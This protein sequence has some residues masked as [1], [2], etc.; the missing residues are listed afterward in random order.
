MVIQT[1]TR[2]IDALTK[3]LAKMKKTTSTACERCDQLTQR[4]RQLDSLTSPASDASSMLSKASNN[5]GA[6]LVL[7]KDAREKFDTI[8]DC[9]PAID[10]LHRGV[11]HM[12]NARSGKNGKGAGAARHNPFGDG[13]H[14]EKE[15]NVILTEQDVYAAADSMEIIRDAYEYFIDRRHWRST[16][17]SL[18]SL[19]RVHQ[20]G[21]S[22][23]CILESFH[24]IDSGQSVRIKRVVKQEGESKTTPD[25]ESAQQ[26]RER[27]QAALHNRDL[28]R[29]IG[30]FEEHQPVEARAVREL[31]GI[32]ESL[33]GN[34][35]QL[36]APYRNE[37]PGLAHHFGQDPKTVVRTEKVGSGMYTNLVQR[38]LKTGF[39]HVDAFGESRKTVSFQCV[40]QYYR[41]LK[42]ERKK[43][44]EKFAANVVGDPAD[45]AARDAV[46][47]L[48]HGM[49]VVAGEKSVYR[50][51]VSP[52]LT[53]IVDE[54][55][56]NDE[57]SPFYRKAC[58]A[59]YSHVAASIVDKA[60][61]IIET[62]F[63]KEGCI[64]HASGSKGEAPPPLT[65][66]QTAAAAAAGLRMLEGVRM[67]GPS[68][69][70]LCI[71]P[72]GD[73]AREPQSLA[74][75]L[76]IAIHR[77]TVKN[78]AR[79]LEN[80]AK[81]IQEDPV[82]GSAQRVKD[83]RVALLTIDVVRAVKLI[84]PFEDAYKS[85]SK[86]R[87]LPWDPNQNEDA[88]ELDS[89]IRFLVMRLVN[90]LRGKA[91]NYTKHSA[92]ISHARSSMFMMNNTF[93][94]RDE[95][96]PTGEIEDFRIHSSWFVDKVNKLFESEKRKYL[97]QW[98]ALTEH[99]T[100]V[101]HDELEYQKNDTILSLDSGRLIKTRFNGF[102]EDFERIFED[103][104]DLCVVDPR[105]R[106]LLQKEVAGVFLPDY[107]L[108]FDKYSKIRFSKKHQSEY[109]KYSPYKI[110]ELLN[111]LYN[112]PE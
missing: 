98:Q 29:S 88:G 72:I 96:G 56:V 64:G 33:G 45:A 106:D 111:Q 58:A 15:K 102:N 6:T 17:N 27:L 94:L 49:V 1:E 19:E 61:D 10:R 62:V 41:R 75:I 71:M 42:Q 107:R 78:T 109:T 40:D 25:K 26:T 16:G 112:D 73:G 51:V 32:F 53:K 12:Q 85:V 21:V 9:E 66:R 101:E 74:S 54:D 38:P 90:S 7:M 24:L 87:A 108:F 46:R 80:L 105:L 103:H 97:G 59:A 34:G 65:V 13:K 23:M 3:S 52:S 93:Y 22:S 110:E 37:P 91:L 92:D 18:S 104:K 44:T 11:V 82:K 55:A 83:A 100:S 68:L 57:I 95:L 48:E 67:L 70:K 86:R 8:V 99:L 77:T 50:N 14:S 84:S 2:R 39:P 89:F 76:C 47:C 30:E 20:M 5:L 79:T 4:A 31:R 81:A 43:N 35:F 69:A 60:M 28:L 36:G 63:L